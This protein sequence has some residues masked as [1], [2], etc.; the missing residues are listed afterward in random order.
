[1]NCVVHAQS[2]FANVHPGRPVSEREVKEWILSTD[3]G[4]EFTGVEA[5]ERLVIVGGSHHRSTL[6]RHASVAESA[7]RQLR[8][9]IRKGL[10]KAGLS[11]KYWVFAAQTWCYNR[12]CGLEALGRHSAFQR[13]AVVTG[14]FRVRCRISTL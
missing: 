2:V 14:R 4:G 8:G 3:G 11:E 12:C 9:G 13:K 5:S 1:M 10:A 7:I 6:H